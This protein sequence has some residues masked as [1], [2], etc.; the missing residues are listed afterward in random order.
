MGTVTN[1]KEYKERK[2][3]PEPGAMLNC[4]PTEKLYKCYI[5]EDEDGT[6]FKLMSKITRHGSIF[7]VLYD[8]WDDEDGFRWKDYVAADVVYSKR[9]F[10]RRIADL[11]RRYELRQVGLANL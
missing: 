4:A 10:R 2:Y 1:I 9:T 8:Q 11:K 5:F 7:Y 3:G 6:I